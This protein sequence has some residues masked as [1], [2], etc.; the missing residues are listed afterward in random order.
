MI[1]IR[2]R[3]AT[4]GALWF[5]EEIPVRPDVDILLLSNRYEA[6]PSRRCVP[7]LTLV[8]DLTLPEERL[9]SGFSRTTQYEI[10]RA[11]ARDALEHSLLTEPAAHL[12][13]FC[14]FY[15]R[16]AATR[17]LFPIYRREVSAACEAGKLV[18][19]AAS[20]A[21]T[22]IVW[23]AYLKSGTRVMLLSPRGESSRSLSCRCSTICN[24]GR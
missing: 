14:D 19:S 4:Y 12:Q 20:H 16:F 1:I 17:S 18:L 6:V 24:D 11:G 5:D 23:H 7:F 10:R 3:V 22:P 15:D 9:F 8:N 2:G 21:G 13:A